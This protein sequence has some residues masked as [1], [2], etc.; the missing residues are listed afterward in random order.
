MQHIRAIY[1]PAVLLRH[2]SLTH[3]RLP[4]QSLS[5]LQKIVVHLTTK[6]DECDQLWK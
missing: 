5:L 3:L 1:A 2:L 6:R 4:T